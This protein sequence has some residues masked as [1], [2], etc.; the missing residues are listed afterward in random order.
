RKSIQIQRE[1]LEVTEK[2]LE[3]KIRAYKNSLENK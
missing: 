3:N 1:N 2:M